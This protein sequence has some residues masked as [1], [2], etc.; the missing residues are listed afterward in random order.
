MDHPDP[1]P[2]PPFFEFNNE[3]ESDLLVFDIPSHINQEPP[4]FEE[5]GPDRVFD[6]TGRLADL[7]VHDYMVVVKGWSEPKI[8]EFDHHLRRAARHHLADEVVNGLGT[9]ELR[10]RLEEVI[11]RWQREHSLS[12]RLAMLGERIRRLVSRRPN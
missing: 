9:F 1:I 6:S 7:G 3:D 10:D 5:F 2:F 11:R 8:D 12:G 4:E